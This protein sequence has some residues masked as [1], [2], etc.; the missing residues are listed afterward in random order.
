M[1]DLIA[2][3]IIIFSGSYFMAWLTNELPRNSATTNSTSIW[4]AISAIVSLIIAVT[5]LLR[6]I[7]KMR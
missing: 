5:L 4:L 3:A 1:D 7:Q 6:L 2:V